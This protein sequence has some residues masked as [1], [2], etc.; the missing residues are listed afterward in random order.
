MYKGHDMRGVLCFCVISE[1][2]TYFLLNMLA[3]AGKNTLKN[4]YSVYIKC[5]SQANFTA[6]IVSFYS[7]FH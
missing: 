2:S 4:T 1:I 7:T 6:I 5:V 3:V